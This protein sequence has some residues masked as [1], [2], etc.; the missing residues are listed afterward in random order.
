M[1]VLDDAGSDVD[2]LDFEDGS[3]RGR[4]A[5]HLA[6]RRQRRRVAT[7]MAVVGVA[8]IV[9]GLSW[10][11][12]R[13]RPGTTPREPATTVNSGAVTE[14]TA[15]PPTTGPGG[16]GVNPE[17]TGLPAVPADHHDP[18][19]DEHCATGQDEIGRAHV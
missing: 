2:A 7:V 13:H 11:P 5:R 4:R 6:G 10:H 19:G 16:V 1:D 12:G 9:F 18:R 17:R 14:N 15:K 3:D 8:A